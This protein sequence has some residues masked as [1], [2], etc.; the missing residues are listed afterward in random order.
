M[1]A[2]LSVSP[3]S[4]ESTISGGEKRELV[5]DELWWDGGFVVE[6]EWWPGRLT[7]FPF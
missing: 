7:A 6:V 1:L 5:A 2:V 4:S 3:Q